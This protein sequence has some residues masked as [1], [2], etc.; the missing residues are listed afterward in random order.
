MPRA[1]KRPRA[2]VVIYELRIELQDIKPMIWR[3]VLVPSIAPLD[4]LHGVI[5]ECFGWQDYHLYRFEVANRAFERPGSG[6]G[7]EDATR[8][9]LGALGL[10][11]GVEFEYQYDFGDGW[12]HRVRLIATHEV[13]PETFYPVCVDGA[14]AGPLEDSGGVPGYENLLKVLANPKH[15]EF[16]HFKEWAGPHYHPEVFDLRATNRILQLAFG[17]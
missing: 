16:P 2:K 15:P 5:Q 8:T 4:Y 14:R 13:E 10:T 6:S 11:D 12:R 1:L 17:L 3:Q 9:E 7:A